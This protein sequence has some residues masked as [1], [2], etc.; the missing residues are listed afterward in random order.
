LRQS[1]DESQ[2]VAAAMVFRPDVFDSATGNNAP[3][4]AHDPIGLRFGPAFDSADLK[5]YIDALRRG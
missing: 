1:L 5:A 4:Q 2:A 3:P